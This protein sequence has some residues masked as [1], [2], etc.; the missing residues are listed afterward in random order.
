MDTSASEKTKLIERVNDFKDYRKDELNLIGKVITGVMLFAYL[1]IWLAVIFKIDEYSPELAALFIFAL[2]VAGFFAM[3]GC[4]LCGDEDYEDRPLKNIPLPIAVNIF[5][6]GG[7]AAM[8]AALMIV[9]GIGYLCLI[10]ADFI[11]DVIVEL[12]I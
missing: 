6:F 10:S 12:L 5:I 8:F 9:G 11:S 3:A 2:F 7:L 1:M 4:V